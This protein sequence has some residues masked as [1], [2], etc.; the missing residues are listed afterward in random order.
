M[1]VVTRRNRETIA[2]DNGRVR[3]VVLGMT[4]S[5]VKIGID[6]PESVPVHRG[7]V[8]ALVDSNGGRLSLFGIALD[9]QA[10]VVAACSFDDAFAQ[11]VEVFGK[12]S[13]YASV[14]R[15]GEVFEPATGHA[16]KI[17]REAVTR[18]GYSIVEDSPSHA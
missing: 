8:Q 7:E 11:S 2:V 14:D 6:A 13:G 10:A 3:F 12:T 5:R 9:K 18:G 17:W 15:F 1:L 16:E 4:K